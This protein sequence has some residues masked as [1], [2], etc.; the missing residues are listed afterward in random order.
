MVK[1]GLLVEQVMINTSFTLKVK[2]EIN[3]TQAYWPEQSV[4]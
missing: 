4:V 2:M 1:E 3:V